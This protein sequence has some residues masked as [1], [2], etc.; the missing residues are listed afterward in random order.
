MGIFYSEYAKRWC[1]GLKLPPK[2]DLEVFYYLTDKYKLGT[3]DYQVLIKQENL[4]FEEDESLIITCPNEEAIG[5]I[6]GILENNLIL[7]LDLNISKKYDIFK[8]RIKDIYKFDNIWFEKK[9]SD[10]SIYFLG[11][12]DNSKYKLRL[13]QD[14]KL[15]L[16]VNNNWKY[17]GILLDDGRLIK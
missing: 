4:N 16:K 5:Y 2:K 17:E 7:D 1:V 3:S 6:M 10:G 8:L 12:K 15:Y 14:N 9:I 13:K 11:E